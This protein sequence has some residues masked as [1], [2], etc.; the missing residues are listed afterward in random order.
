VPKPKFCA[1]GR[2]QLG[3]IIGRSVSLVRATA[4][5]CITTGCPE[6]QEGRRHQTCAARL[7]GHVRP[8]RN[9]QPVGLAQPTVSEHSRILK[10][11]RRITGKLDGPR[12]C[13]RLNPAALAPRAEF[14]ANLTPPPGGACW[15]PEGKEST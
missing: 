15:V 3:L 13:N 9:H 10:A 1:F 14:I 12:T 8:S 11:A 7:A 4:I 2:R 5:P 6:G